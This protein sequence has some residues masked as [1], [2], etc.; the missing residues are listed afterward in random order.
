[1]RLPCSLCATG[2]LDKRTRNGW[3]IRC[4]LDL[5]YLACLEVEG[6]EMNEKRGPDVV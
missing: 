5:G 4:L 2:P 6:G 3:G 1:M